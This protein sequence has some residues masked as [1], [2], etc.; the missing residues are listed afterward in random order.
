MNLSKVISRTQIHKSSPQGSYQ[1]FAVLLPLLET[2]EGIKIL[3]EVRSKKLSKQPGEVCFPGG[4][5]DLGESFVQ[6]AIRETCE[7]LNIEGK[8]IEIVGE[9]DYLVTPYNLIIYPFVGVIKGV[10]Y[11]SLNFN[12]DEVE[13]VFTMDLS[14]PLEIEADMHVV[15]LHAH[16]KNNFP[17]HLV[18]QGKDYRWKIGKYPVPF[19][20]YDNKIIWGFTARI[21]SNFVDVLKT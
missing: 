18:I 3:F 17:Y 14:F 21:L 2:P 5:V 15:D 9:L 7:E 10:D 11:N 8:N 13:S 16:P 4:K 19:Y 6:A 20:K 12:Q 1:N